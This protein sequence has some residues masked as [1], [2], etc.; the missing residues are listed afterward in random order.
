MTK[1]VMHN[2][3]THG[4]RQQLIF[5]AARGFTPSLARGWE[6][7]GLQSL[8]NPVMFGS[9]APTPTRVDLTP[10]EGRLGVM[11][12]LI[13]HNP[14]SKCWGALQPRRGAKAAADTGQEGILL[15][16]KT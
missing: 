8:D 10:R 3:H 11:K 5:T 12:R 16:S 13:L 7:G 14:P 2:K 15:Q 1:Q 9:K 6:Q 4:P